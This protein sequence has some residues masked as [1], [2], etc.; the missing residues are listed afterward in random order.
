MNAT[1]PMLLLENDLQ[2]NISEGKHNVQMA[3][4]ISKA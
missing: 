2:A 4:G 3:N 1:E